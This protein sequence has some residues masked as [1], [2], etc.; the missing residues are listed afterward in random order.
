MESI[1]QGNGMIRFITVG[2]T[3]GMGG[4]GAQGEMLP[5]AICLSLGDEVEQKVKHF[6]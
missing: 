4:E 3:G 1:R 6:Y 2:G 5:L